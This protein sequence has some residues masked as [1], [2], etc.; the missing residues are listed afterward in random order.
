MD[1]E[2]VDSV[3]KRLA[4]FGRVQAKEF[5]VEGTDYADQIR[6][7][8]VDENPNAWWSGTWRRRQCFRSDGERVRLSPSTT[9]TESI[10]TTYL[11]EL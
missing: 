8:Q 6:V 7:I 9:C 1:N 11:K 3:R 5:S 4:E 2:S 10:L